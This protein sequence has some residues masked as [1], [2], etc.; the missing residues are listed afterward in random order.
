MLHL[1]SIALVGLIFL[2]SCKTPEYSNVEPFNSTSVADTD[3]KSHK[4][5]GGGEELSLT[6]NSPKV[7]E[8]IPDG[9]TWKV[10]LRLNGRCDPHTLKWLEISECNLEVRDMTTTDKCM[11]YQI[12]TEQLRR[13]KDCDEIIINGISYSNTEMEL[14]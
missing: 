7:L 5:Q 8:V 6:F 13:N 1:R 12:I 4:E 14:E 2:V 9:K 10:K 11:G 3:R